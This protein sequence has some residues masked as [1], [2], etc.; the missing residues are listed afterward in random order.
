M[1]GAKAS[2]VARVNIQKR[3]RGPRVAL[4]GRNPRDAVGRVLRSEA[5][6]TRVFYP[7]LFFFFFFAK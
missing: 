3:R 2:V 6:V 4:D 7:F 1:L 5:T